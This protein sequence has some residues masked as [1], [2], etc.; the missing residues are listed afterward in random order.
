MIDVNQIENVTLEHCENEILHV[1]KFAHNTG[2]AKIPGTLRFK[3]TTHTNTGYVIDKVQ[4]ILNN[5]TIIHKAII[6]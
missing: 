5:I 4:D 6:P 2:K 1:R 3:I